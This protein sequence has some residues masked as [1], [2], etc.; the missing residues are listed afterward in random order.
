[1]TRWE[2]MAV[3]ID[4]RPKHTETFAE[5]TVD[6][7]D[8]VEKALDAWGAE[9]WQVVAIDASSAWRAILKRELPAGG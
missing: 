7:Y 2:Y 3:Q 5:V 9:G 4:W 8:A 6:R 1:M